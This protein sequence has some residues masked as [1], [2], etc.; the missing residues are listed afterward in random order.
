VQN[1][2]YQSLGGTKKYNWKVWETF[3]DKVGWRK[4]GKWLMWEQLTY[5]DHHYDGHLPFWGLDGLPVGVGRG[6][7][8][9][10]IFSRAETC[11]L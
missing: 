5:D 11:R 1:K 8:G 2:I 4:G 3:C 7:L 6:L 9:T 10:L